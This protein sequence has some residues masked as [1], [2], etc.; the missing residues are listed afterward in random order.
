MP[1]D[2]VLVT[3]AT[4][5]FGGN[6]ARVLCRRGRRVR[7]LTR[8]GRRPIA[9]DGLDCEIV[10]GDLIDERAIVR[11]V[12]GCRQVYHAAASIV[13]WCRSRREL[14]AVRR[15]TV[16]GTRAILRAAA[17]AGVER[18]VH[19]STVDVIG[20]PPPGSVATETTDW[21]PGRIE[22]VYAA[23]KRD[24][25]AAALD[26][27]VDT[28]IVN[29]AFMIGALDPKPSSGRLLLPLLRAPVVFFPSRG[30]NNFVHVRDVVE[31]TL[32][33]MERGRRG[34][35]Y[36]LGGEN[37]TYRQLFERA[38]SVIGRRPLLVPL[39]RPVAVLA[40]RAL[41][42]RARLTGAEPALTASLARLAFAGH[43]YDS[44]KAIR[45]LG[46]PHTP[47]DQALREALAWLRQRHSPSHVPESR[48]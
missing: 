17:T 42:A 12:A 44:A 10:E 21:P 29:P 33:A 46:L 24:A 47:I 7:V 38:L 26:A 8:S 36:I 16:G 34:E 15:V 23:T 27:S 30:G 41:E 22:T 40:G 11:A 19:V 2:L 37:L 18:V 20:L 6:L 43:Y 5:F 39:A 28:V 9:L 3:G 1:S 14:D 32:S 45:E 31:G 48:P 13:F 25:E 35:R 4:G